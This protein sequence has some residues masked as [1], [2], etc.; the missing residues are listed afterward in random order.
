MPVFRNQSGISKLAAILIVFLILIF[1][2]ISGALFLENPQVTTYIITVQSS[3]GSSSAIE[4]LRTG[5]SDS[6]QNTSGSL[7]SR[8]TVVETLTVTE[9]TTSVQ[10]SPDTLVV[11]ASASMTSNS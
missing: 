8:G 10:T 9:T 7:S 11:S 1:A 6:V 4:T 3:N 2:S 5:A